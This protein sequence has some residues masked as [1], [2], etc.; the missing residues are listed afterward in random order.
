MNDITREYLLRKA[1]DAKYLV[2]ESSNDKKYITGFATKFHTCKDG[3]HLILSCLSFKSN[4]EAIADIE[5]LKAKL[6]SDEKV[7]A[8]VF[9]SYI[10]CSTNGDVIMDLG[11][12]KCKNLTFDRFLKN[13]TLKL[14]M[15][16]L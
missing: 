3:R 16:D 6:T 9:A 1:M 4:D 13:Y 11:W 8:H 15:T 7:M 5:T 12:M 10:P 14:Y 2:Q